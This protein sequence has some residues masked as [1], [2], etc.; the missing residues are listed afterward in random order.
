M[1]VINNMI[2]INM[3]RTKAIDEQLVKLCKEELM[4]LSHLCE[5]VV[6]V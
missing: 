1:K 2:I 6:M 4:A 3:R 5:Q